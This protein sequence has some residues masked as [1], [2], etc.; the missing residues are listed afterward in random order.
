MT[1]QQWGRRGGEEYTEMKAN[2]TVWKENN[3][4][5]RPIH[6]TKEGINNDEGKLQSVEWGIQTAEGE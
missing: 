6:C 2:N 5:M 4:A 1:E 3:R